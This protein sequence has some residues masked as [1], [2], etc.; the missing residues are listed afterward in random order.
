MP[1]FGRVF[2]QLKKRQKAHLEVSVGVLEDLTAEETSHIVAVCQ[3]R[4]NTVNRQAFRDC[5][6]TV[7]SQKKP[8]VSTDDDLLALQNKL[9][10]RKGTKA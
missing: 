10:Q 6:Q 3:R 7:L 1:L 4:E 2:A 8:D 9:K 5:V